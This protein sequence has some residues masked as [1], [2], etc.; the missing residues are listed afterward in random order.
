MCAPNRVP[1]LRSLNATQIDAGRATEPYIIH[2]GLHCKVGAFAFTKYSHGGF[3]AVGCTGKVFG[4]PPQ[5]KHLER[6]CAETVLTLNDAMCDFY[7]RPESEHGC[8]LSSR[9]TCPAWEPFSGRSC[10]ERGGACAWRG[11]GSGGG[12]LCLSLIHI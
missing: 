2:Y 7:N 9:V 6:L 5:P 8:G 12:G 3:D 10:G 4:D 1:W 11:S